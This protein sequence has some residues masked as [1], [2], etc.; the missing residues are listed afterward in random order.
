MYSY[1]VGAWSQCSITCGSGGVQRRIVLCYEINPINRRVDDSHCHSRGLPRQQKS[2]ICTAVACPT[3][4]TPSYKYRVGQWEQCSATCGSG[5][6]NRSVSCFEAERKVSDSYCKSDN[7]LQ[8][9][10]KTRRCQTTECPTYAYRHGPW[11]R[12]SV[13]CGQ[14]TQIRNVTCHET[15][16][17][18]RMVSNLHCQAARLKQPNRSRTCRGAVCPVYGYFIGSWGPCSVTCGNGVQNRDVSCYEL[19]PRRRRVSDS[20]CEALGYLR[21]RASQRCVM[22]ACPVYEYRVGSWGRCS[23]MCGNGTRNRSVACSEVI[24]LQRTVSNAYCQ[25]AGLEQPDA[26]Q[27]CRI[28]CAVYKYQPGPWEPCPVQCGNGTQRRPLTC[29]ETSPLQREVDIAQCRSVGAEQPDAIRDCRTECEYRY[30]MWDYCRQCE[31]NEQNESV[32]CWQTS[33]SSRKLDSNLCANFG[34]NRAE[35]R[36]MDR[37]HSQCLGTGYSNSYN[38]STILFSFRT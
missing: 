3:T 33:P 12:C 2:R 28:D 22:N 11:Q 9:P 18:E 34:T 38:I 29:F 8:E 35:V 26:S 36:K 7:Q 4:T 25:S 16:P 1:F 21:A 23:G 20:F 6:Q 5:T 27:R 31:K 17:S 32:E 30:V 10:A 37:C 19:S 14:G 13:T 24:P 15:S